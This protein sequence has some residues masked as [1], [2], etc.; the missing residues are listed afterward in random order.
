MIK[1]AKNVASNWLR[2]DEFDEYL[3]SVDVVCY[4]RVIIYN[5]VEA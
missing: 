5:I 3:K 2:K 1:C 4:E